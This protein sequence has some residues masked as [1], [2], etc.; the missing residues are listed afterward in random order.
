MNSFI[1]VFKY[2]VA[3]QF[4]LPVVFNIP[5]QVCHLQIDCTAKH[6]QDYLCF[7]MFMNTIENV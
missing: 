3:A 5:L 4:Y 2:S 6:K 1:D 7:F